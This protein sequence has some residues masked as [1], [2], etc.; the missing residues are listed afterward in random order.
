MSNDSYLYTIFGDLLCLA[1]VLFLGYW[2]G[3]YIYH[4]IFLGKKIKY[5][6]F[7]LDGVQNFLLYISGT[8]KHQEMSSKKYLFHILIFS[9]LGFL[10]LFILLMMQGYLLL[11]PNNINNMRWDVALNTAFS[12]VT[13]TNWQAYVGEN[14]VSYLSST[15]GLT[16]QNFLSASVGMC[17]L[18][19]LIR[20]LTN[21]QSKLVGNFYYDISRIIIYLLLPLSIVGALLLVSQG[22]PQTYSSNI[23]YVDYINS[24]TNNQFSILNLGPVASQVIIKQLGT[25]GGGFYGANS[26]H[27]FENPTA[28]S[29]LIQNVSMLL[30]PVSLCYT[31]GFSVNDKKHSYMFLQVMTFLFV[32]ALMCCT[33]SEYTY[34]FVVNS[35]VYYG[36]MSGKESRF[37]IG[38]SSFWSISTTSTSTGSINSN[39]NQYTPLGGMILLIL[40]EFGEIVYGGIGS[41]LYG[42]IGFIILTIFISGLII[43]KTPEYLGKKIDSFDMKMV[44][45]LILPSPI[46]AMGG[47]AISTIVYPLGIYSEKG[48]HGFTQLL[49]GYTSMANNN[50]SS[51]NGFK[52][53]ALSNIMGGFIMGIARFVPIVAVGLMSENLSIKKISNSNSNQLKTNNTLFAILL[54]GIIVLVGALG[55]FPSWALGPIAEATSI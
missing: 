20:G 52:H 41:G 15:L 44:C 39:L 27:P 47:T 48:A 4:Y 45:L 10:F 8:S 17:V 7:P 24:S 50:G 55:F 16:T 2:I 26:A 21:K 54:V 5:L 40:M 28:F 23:K 19:L 30:I 31:F 11:N 38:L 29:N 36:N 1:I 3:K 6:S 9:F 14:E 32:V 49:Y 34:K 33:I 25:N 22:V 46:L 37:G 12:F 35:N 43:G 13:N 18:F 53:N 51:F 42:I